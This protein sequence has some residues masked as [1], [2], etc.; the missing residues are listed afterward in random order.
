MKKLHVIV[1]ECG[2][3][4]W[5][6]QGLEIDYVSDGDTYDKAVGNFERG[7]RKTEQRHLDKFGDLKKLENRRLSV[8][9]LVKQLHHVGEANLIPVA[10]APGFMDFIRER[11]S[12]RLSL[13]YIPVAQTA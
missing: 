11:F 10:K 2:S 6:A 1:I 4:H 7:F 3:G 13:D 9:A 8:P 12:S 5:L